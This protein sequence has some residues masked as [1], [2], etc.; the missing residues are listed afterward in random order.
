M[1]NLFAKKEAAAEI[2]PEVG[3]ESLSKQTG[4][5]LMENPPTPPKDWKAFKANSQSE[6]VN[7]MNDNKIDPEF[8]FGG[9]NGQINIFYK[10]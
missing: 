3:I 4:V 10:A 8:I 1:K 5:P 2:K 7:F 9:S 6:A